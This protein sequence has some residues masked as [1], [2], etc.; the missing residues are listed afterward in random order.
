MPPSDIP[1]QAPRGEA[2]DAEDIAAG[3]GRQRVRRSWGALVW[4]IVPG[5]ALAGV[6]FFVAVIQGR[7]AEAQLE[8]M[9]AR[10]RAAGFALTPAELE[11][12]LPAV[13]SPANGAP[14]YLEA[15]ERY[16]ADDDE[17]RR[18][19]DAKI[20]PEAPFE[21]QGL[22]GEEW[23]VL[24][25][26]LVTSNSEVLD[27]LTSAAAAE[28]SR[29]CCRDVPPAAYPYLLGRSGKTQDNALGGV[30]YQPF[31]ACVRLLFCAAVLH[32]EKGE[33]APALARLEE[34]LIMGRNLENDPG[35]SSQQLRFRGIGHLLNGLERVLARC[36]PSSAD[37]V[38]WHQMLF[39][40][41]ETLSIRRFIEGEIAHVSILYDRLRTR[42]PEV[43]SAL[44]LEPNGIA[45]FLF[46]V[47]RANLTT[48]EAAAL[49]AFLETAERARDIN[50][51]GWRDITAD[52]TER[53]CFAA[54]SLTSSWRDISPFETARARLLTAATG[55]AAARFRRDHGR[56]PSSLGDICPAY[57]PFVPLDPFA[58][59]APLIFKT[60]PDGLTVYS[61]GLN[62]TDDGGDD[63]KDV[64]FRVFD[65]ETQRNAQ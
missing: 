58:N 63:E 7:R 23:S 9:R 10:A 8:A 11:A 30:P 15:F 14:L 39:D 42:D 44:G 46:R 61:V 13:D 4:L 50:R 53:R 28:Y 48:D 57:M 54:R 3:E 35:L 17:I 36:E 60:S 40:D 19:F 33:T 38:R 21:P 12:K 18:L 56:L 37:L 5:L 55:V 31:M 2:G 22:L 1:Q 24:A 45:G 6:L 51:G 34:I 52:L 49:E 65:V 20:P 26:S 41:A 47:Y 62:R 59:G 64:V 32:A 25:T 43:T 29:F 16:A 27:L